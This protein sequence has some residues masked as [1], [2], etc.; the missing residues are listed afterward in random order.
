MIYADS[1][2]NWFFPYKVLFEDEDIL[3][4]KELPRCHRFDSER[5]ANDPV[6]KWIDFLSNYTYARVDGTL[7]L[8]EIQR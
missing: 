5:G 1:G 4:L 8:V 6:D 3:I 7:K 2:I